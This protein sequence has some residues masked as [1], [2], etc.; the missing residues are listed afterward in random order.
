M[1]QYCAI[2]RA[3]ANEPEVLLMEEPSG[4]WVSY[5]PGIANRLRILH[6]GFE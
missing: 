5:K 2:A 4:A 6:K 3:S 1:E